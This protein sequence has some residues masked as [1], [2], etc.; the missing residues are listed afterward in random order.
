M[1][2]NPGNPDPRAGFRLIHPLR[3]RYNEA[4]M[5]GIVF[6]ANYLVYADI[7][8]TAYFR[9]LAMATF[10]DDTQPH[11]A[12]FLGCFGGDC[13][14]RHADVDFRAPA[15][16]DDLLDICVRITRFGR[17]SFS[18]LTHIVRDD[19]LLNAIQLTQVWFDRATEEVSPVHQG[20]IDAVHA[21]E[22]VAPAQ[23][24]PA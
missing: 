2:D 5:Q 20:F 1:I 7:G 13:W 9:A 4:D 12:D 23:K 10:P 24:L 8:I 16:A 15:R 6:N 11:A 3:V 14:V 19:R 17:T 18:T 22:A 21:Y